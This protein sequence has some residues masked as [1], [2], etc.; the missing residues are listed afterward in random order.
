MPELPYFHGDLLEAGEAVAQLVQQ[1]E[2]QESG[3]RLEAWQCADKSFTKSCAWVKK[4]ADHAQAC[5]GQPREI[6]EAVATHPT[7][8]L[9]EQSAVW[10]S[11]WT[12]PP[13][14]VFDPGPL[15]QVLSEL[16]RPDDIHI[17]LQVSVE[18]LRKATR[19][20]LKKACGPDGWE[21]PALCRREVL[22]GCCPVVEL[23]S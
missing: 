20:M 10:T 11:L 13:N 23:G 7:Q 5:F 1:Y 12:L 9:R 18:G 2:S 3:A 4:K 19:R 22:G 21:A 6:R 8:I 17:D 15:R 16:P 14:A